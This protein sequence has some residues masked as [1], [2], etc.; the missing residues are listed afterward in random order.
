MGTYLCSF[1]FTSNSTAQLVMILAYFIFGVVLLLVSFALY[2]FESTKKA[3]EKLRFFFRC[4]PHFALA[5]TIFFMSIRSFFGGGLWDLDVSG[6]NLIF[7]AWESVA[8]TILTLVVERLF[9]AQDLIASLV[10][11]TTTNSIEMQAFQD[12]DDVQAEK[13]RIKAGN[14][15]EDLIRLEGL[16]K[17]YP[18]GKVAVHDLWYAIPRNECFG[19]LGVNGAGKSTTLKI[20]T[21]DEVQTKGQAFI[22][23]HNISTEPETVRRH[24]GYCPQF[25]AIHDL[26]TAEEHL[27]FYGRIRGVAEANLERV[28]ETLC[29]R[30]TLD[31]DGQHRRPSETYS[32]GNKRKLSV[33]IS[34][35]G[36]PPVV[37]LDEPSTGMDP[38]SRRFMWDFLSQTMAQRAVILTTHSME[39]CEA[40][41][42]RIGIQVMG[43]LR[44]LGSAQ[45]LKNKYGRGFQVDVSVFNESMVPQVRGFFQ[46]HFQNVQ[47]IECFG[48]AMKFRIDPNMSLAD[49][50]SVIE[51]NKKNLGIVQYGVGQT[52]LDQIF[53]Q[54]ARQG[55]HE[56]LAKQVEQQNIQV[57]P[58]S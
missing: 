45:H 38:V 40:L 37:F 8:Y 43:R 32:G 46:H 15:N 21:G 2:S 34:L 13:D 52:S 17:V 54:F 6:Y 23:G 31:Q 20:L 26:L 22:A 4:F 9:A 25:D 50:F 55:D 27:Y 10:N 57:V 33:A 3:N 30:L 29:Q 35:I 5:D 11:S 1:L 19:F 18:N 47:E 39:E 14:A 24:I 42:S 51:T 44:C 36:N 16:R 49:V 53:I 41:C 58:H 48:G 28:I 7:M 12:D 56:E